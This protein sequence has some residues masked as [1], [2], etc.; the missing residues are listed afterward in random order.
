MRKSARCM[1]AIAVLTTGM[2]LAGLA[3]ETQHAYCVRPSASGLHQS[4][5]S[6]D[7]GNDNGTDNSGETGAGGAAGGAGGGG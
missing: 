1:A 4:A 7:D 5:G 6:G 2:G 3:A